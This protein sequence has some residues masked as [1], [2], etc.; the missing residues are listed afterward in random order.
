MSIIENA[1]K[2]RCRQDELRLE[3]ELERARQPEKLAEIE[4]LRAAVSEA[5]RMFRWYGDL[6]T[7]KPDHEKARRNYDMADKMATALGL[8]N[9]SNRT[10]R[11]SDREECDLC[12]N[13]GHCTRQCE[14][15]L[16]PATKD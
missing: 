2:S 3:I 1:I 12:D 4:R 14:P 10:R 15:S 11:I 9:R 5:E 13:D 7:A 16:N 6:H 8:E